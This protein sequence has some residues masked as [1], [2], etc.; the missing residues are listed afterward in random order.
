MTEAMTP[1]ER[2][3]EAIRSLREHDDGT[4]DVPAAVRQAAEAFADTECA[5]T[6]DCDGRWPHDHAACRAA[7]LREIG[8]G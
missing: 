3:V 4:W 7:L 5:N 6:D 1:R 2:F 8:L